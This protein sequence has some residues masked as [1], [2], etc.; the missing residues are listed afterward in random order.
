MYLNDNN[1]RTLQYYGIYHAKIGKI[2]EAEI[3]LNKLKQYITDKNEKYLNKNDS[4]YPVVKDFENE[5]NKSK[6]KTKKRVLGPAWTRNE[7][8]KPQG[9]RDMGGWISYVYTK[10]QQIRLRVDEFGNKIDFDESIN[11]TINS[12]IKKMN[13]SIVEKI[14]S[15]ENIQRLKSVIIGL[16][17]IVRNVNIDIDVNE[18][19]ETLKYA[20]IK[21]KGD[22]V[23]LTNTTTEK[24]NSLNINYDFIVIGGGPS[25][26]MC[27]YRLSKLNPTKSIL[28]LEK[29]KHTY[30]DY[31]KAGYNEIKNW[32]KA[33]G[34]SRFTTAFSSMPYDICKNKVEIQLGNGL[35][36]GTLHFGL[37]FIDQIN[38]LKRDSWEFSNNEYTDILND[39]NEICQTKTYDYSDESFP[40]VLKDLKTM[41]ETNSNNK[42]EVFNNKIY[43]RD[44][45]TRFSLSELLLDRNNITVWHNKNVERIIYDTW[46]LE[47]KKSSF[48]EKISFFDE[49]DNNRFLNVSKN[50]QVILCAGAVD[51]PSI[52]QRSNICSVDFTQAVVKPDIEL[53]VGETLFDHV[54]L[55]L[56]YMHRDFLPKPQQNE[57]PTTPQ[58][59]PKKEEPPTLKREK[60]LLNRDAL[61]KIGQFFEGIFLA[62][63][64]NIPSFDKNYVWDF[65]N[66]SQIHPG[67]QQNILKAKNNNYVLKFPHSMGRW[68]QR[69]SNFIKIG[70]FNKEIDFDD[71]PEYMKTNVDFKEFFDNGKFRVETRELTKEKTNEK[72]EKVKIIKNIAEIDSNTIGHIQ[73]RE[74][75]N[76]WQTYYSLIPDY[77]KDTLMPILIT[78]FATSGKMNNDGYVKILNKEKINPLVYYNY[79]HED[80]L[81]DLADAFLDNHKA[82][83]SG[84]NKEYPGEYIL[85]DPSLN[86]YAAT[87]DK[88]SIKTYFKTRLAS[89]YH[90]H[91]TCPLNKV[92][93]YFQ[94]VMKLSNLKIGDLSIL[95]SPVAG[96]TSV[97]AM[98]CGYRCANFLSP[99]NVRYLTDKQL[100]EKD[101][102]ESDEKEDDSE[103]TSEKTEI[104]EP[105]QEEI[106]KVKNKLPFRSNNPVKIR[107]ANDDFKIQFNIVNDEIIFTLDSNKK[108]GLYS[109]KKGF[110]VEDGKLKVNQKEMTNDLTIYVWEKNNLISNRVV[111]ENDDSHLCIDK[112]LTNPNQHRGVVRS[113]AGVRWMP[114]SEH[115]KLPHL[116]Q[117]ILGRA[118]WVSRKLYY[119]LTTNYGT[120]TENE[121]KLIK[122]AFQ[123]YERISE[124][125]FIETDN[126][127]LADIEIVRE[128]VNPMN[129]KIVGSSYGP[130]FYGAEVKIYTGAYKSNS[131]SNYPKGGYI[132]GWDYATFIHEIGHSLGLMHPHE[133]VEGSIKME[134]VMFNP[135]TGRFIT[136]NKA[137][138]FPFT[139]MSYN[140]ITSAYTPNFTLKYG[141][142]SSLGPIDVAAIQAVYGI[143][144][145]YNSGDN[146]YKIISVSQN[147]TGWQSIYDTGGIDQINAEH[148]TNNTLI[149]LQEADITKKDGSGMEVSK[150]S[151]IWGGY[152]IVSGAQIENAIG[153]DYD[154]VIVENKLSNII[155]GKKGNDTVYTLDV[156]S[157]YLLFKNTDET[158]SLVN[159][160]N[161]NETNILKNI[162]IIVYANAP[163]NIAQKLSEFEDD[164]ILPE[165]GKGAR[166]VIEKKSA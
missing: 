119:I 64:N 118:V 11:S 97:A 13:D 50:T 124:L 44:L 107:R 67:G 26:I 86:V 108:Y 80:N 36:G 2:N 32:L 122:H 146:V 71:F 58:I 106:V 61:I 53:P 68:N 51:S 149:N 81:N 65:K 115:K 54:G 155:D 5:I 62:T 123:Q 151:K 69:K 147:E 153:G 164:F 129:Q 39:I 158:I 134:N 7:I 102:V 99:E 156:Q 152:T 95:T 116:V 131:Y 85:A 55:T 22:F 19:D 117:S 139:V 126:W 79:A 166:I 63:G 72:I 137:N 127:N 73:T 70:E 75:N 21:S 45:K 145:N 40:K 60:I 162:E 136:N 128:N 6:N 27:A 130:S 76:N 42:Y 56:T 138:A 57:P 52:L 161:D 140:D 120:W 121:K 105:K 92:V 114:K 28:I 132:G 125:T 144:K 89:I 103:K 94:G 49:T 104:N 82:I 78:T 12:T 20:Q 163:T 148:S 143:N 9:E 157:N 34:D 29:N 154:D 48:V 133:R 83:S 84:N 90:Y 14:K 113:Y 30:E 47:E 23:V 43:S 37:Q 135:M 87:D 150:V 18:I 100:S 159:V 46:K 35:G 112:S 88:E 16:K 24:I 41:L 10:E 96:S 77:P 25:G 91:G 98:C 38:V 17:E 110:V 15:G 59:T 101:R 109:S 3:F 8:E 31:K 66:W 142:M 160:K 33:S 74:L 1:W 4:W 141:Y 93:D 111:V 165:S